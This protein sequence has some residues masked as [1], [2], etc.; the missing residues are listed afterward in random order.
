MISRLN[1]AV[2]GWDE[3]SHHIFLSISKY[4]IEPLRYI[5]NLSFSEGVVPI[6]MK[7]ARVVPL[8]KAQ[9]PHQFSNYRPISILPIISKILERLVHTRL[10]KF[11]TKY[12]I[13]YKYQ[14]GFREQHSTDLALNLLNN[15]IVSSLHSLHKFHIRVFSR[16]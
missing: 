2:P 15:Y 5:I 14:F 8:L 10:S 4:L 7:I 3:L 9:D 12:D 13:L 1:D 11:L 16:F 6:E